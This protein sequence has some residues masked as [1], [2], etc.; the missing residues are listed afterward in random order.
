MTPLMTEP[1]FS[2]EMKNSGGYLNFYGFWPLC[3]KIAMSQR[4]YEFSQ[5]LLGLEFIMG[6]HVVHLDSLNI[7][8]SYLIYSREA[9]QF[10]FSKTLK[11]SSF[12]K[13]QKY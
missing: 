9:K 4:F 3:H 5:L 13:F 8:R 1:I 6:T 10:F 12:I 11:T 7:I 2:K